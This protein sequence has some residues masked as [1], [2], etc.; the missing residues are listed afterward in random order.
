M[1]TSYDDSHLMDALKYFNNNVV[2]KGT[3][4]NDYSIW[5]DEPKPTKKRGL[6]SAIDDEVQRI[7]AL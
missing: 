4:G 6:Q 1:G 2:H 5:I 7:Q 3:D